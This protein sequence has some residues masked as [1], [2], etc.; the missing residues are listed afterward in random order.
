MDRFGSD[1]GAS[2]R[3]YL[4]SEATVPHTMFFSHL[5]APDT[6]ILQKDRQAALNEGN[7]SQIYWQMRSREDAGNHPRELA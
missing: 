3:E 5:G 2:F 4:G 6:I 1:L 7:P